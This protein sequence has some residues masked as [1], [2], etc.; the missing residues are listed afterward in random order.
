VTNP[1]G[2]TNY[3]ASVPAA[4]GTT[5]IWNLPSDLNN[6]VIYFDT[7]YTHSSKTGPPQVKNRE[8]SLED[9]YGTGAVGGSFDQNEPVSKIMD[10]YAAMSVNDPLS[11]AA[12][13]KELL[14][15]GFY[16]PPGTTILGGM[17]Q[18]TQDALIKAMRQYLQVS[19]TGTGQSFTKFLAG[20]A[21]ANIGINGN[22]PGSAGSG[23][24]TPILTDPDTLT[25][26]AQM[27]A[28][29]ALGR[30]L[31]KN[32]LTKFVDQFHNEQINSYTQAAGHNGLSAMK[33][34]PRSS[35]IDFV[36]SNNQPEF[37][38]HQIQG[39]ADSFL[40]MFLPSSS[41]APNVSV[42]PQAVGY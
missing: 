26:Y 39:Y 30:A 36:T 25:R 4:A 34:D 38:Q 1:D 42:D 40:N 23:S 9:K 27:A 41:A 5:T 20:E 17:K 7:G 12:L 21:A 22:V 15:A 8:V 33:D 18:Q 3:G 37:E 2:T 11:F 35:A 16:G 13:Q 24:S 32:E 29:N 10:H 6:K 31:T 19:Q 28:E 14:D